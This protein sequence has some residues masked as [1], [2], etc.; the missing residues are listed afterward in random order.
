SDPRPQALASIAALCPPGTQHLPPLQ[1]DVLQADWGLP[2]A[3]FDAVFCAN[4]L[5][6][7]PW[8][9]CAALMG[10]SARHLRAGGQLLV[11]GPFLVPGVATAPSNLAFDADLRGRDPAWGLRS[12]DAVTARA[13]AAG[14]ELL[15]TIAMPAN[16]LL[17]LFRKE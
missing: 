16:N 7:S 8:A 17:L 6:I 12:L 10:G 11:Y 4:L 9:T 15:Q 3:A 2:P 1:L 5:H 13:Q 14:L